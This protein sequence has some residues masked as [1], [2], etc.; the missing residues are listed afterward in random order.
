MQ[1]LT[2]TSL[3][4]QGT[5]VA[6]QRQPRVLVDQR[7][8]V[9]HLRHHGRRHGL[10]GR[11]CQR[12]VRHAAAIARV[13]VQRIPERER[14]LQPCVRGHCRGQLGRSPLLG[15][16]PVRA[17]RRRSRVGAER[18]ACCARVVRHHGGERRGAVV[19]HL[20]RPASCSVSATTAGASSATAASRPPTWPKPWAV[21]C[22]CA[23]SPPARTMPA[24]WTRRNA[25][26][27]GRAQVSRRNPAF[28]V[29]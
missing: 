29:T 16:Q 1:D 19:L 24:R 22:H 9:F 5:T 18:R 2:P 17:G 3:Q 28:N 20:R 27:P 15:Q 13:H 12:P 11:H 26:S 23:A 14:R 21:A 25:P 4:L 10:L 8:P 6:G 7:G